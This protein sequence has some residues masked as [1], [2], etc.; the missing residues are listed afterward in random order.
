MS[1]KDGCHS[2]EEK[3]LSSLVCRPIQFLLWQFDFNI[4]K[5]YV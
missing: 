1:R 4:H 5:T 3:V 2:E